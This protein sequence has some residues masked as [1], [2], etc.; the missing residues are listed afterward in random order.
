V[1]EDNLVNQKMVSAILL[2]RGYRVQITSNGQEA[3]QALEKQQFHLVLMDVQMPV[4][5]GLEATRLIRKDARWANLPIIA[6][7]AHA[8]NGDKEGCLAAGMNAYISKPVHSAHLLSI[9]QP[10]ASNAKLLTS[11]F[12]A[13]F[14][15]MLVARPADL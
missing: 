10:G 13:R 6:M 12:R 5:D 8:M 14:S 9:Y 4:L 11:H 15:A 2:K 7:T 1:V 3:L